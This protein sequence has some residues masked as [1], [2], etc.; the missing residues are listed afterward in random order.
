MGWKKT[1]LGSEEPT[2]GQISKVLLIWLLLAG[3]VMA[4]FINFIPA[5]FYAEIDMK[6]VF[7]GAGMAATMAMLFHG[8]RLGTLQLHFQQGWFKAILTWAMMPPILGFVFWLV[9][10]KSVPWSWTR[11]FGEAYKQPVVMSTHYKRSRRTCDYRL[12]GGPLERSFPG[13]ICISEDAYKRYPEQD[14]AVIVV[15]KRSLLGSTIQEV[16]LETRD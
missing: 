2:L 6:V 5:P 11:V 3:V 10:T 14:V 13:Y 9:L 16:Y 8:F 7:L 15:G 1:W 4:L 12:K